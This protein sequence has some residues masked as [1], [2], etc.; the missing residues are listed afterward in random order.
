MQLLNRGQKL[1]SVEDAFGKIS[2]IR[3][4]KNKIKIYINKFNDFT[5]PK[6]TLTYEN[7]N[8]L[9]EEQEKVLNNF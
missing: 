6:I 9:L 7:V 1:K 4:L 8:K 5:R 3:K 2:E